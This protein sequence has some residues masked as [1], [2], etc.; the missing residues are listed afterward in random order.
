M[1]TGLETAVVLLSLVSLPFTLPIP[2]SSVEGDQSSSPVPPDTGHVYLQPD[3]F[4]L[5]E[6]FVDI[7][8]RVGPSVVTI[9]SRRTYTALV[10]EFPSAPFDMWS[11]PWDRDWERMFP[12][13]REREFI[14]EGLGSGVIATP[15]GYIISNHHVVGEADD[16]EVI[17][18]SG[19]RYRA[20]LVGTD[21]R[22]DI[23]VI[24]IDAEHPLPC[25]DFGTSSDLRVG[26]WV[27]AIGS[28][29]ALSQ[30]VT[31]GIVSFIGRSNVGLSDLENY[32]QTDAAIN[33][34]NSGG[35]LVNLHGELVGIN[36]AIASVTGGY[37]GVGFAIPVD[38]VLDVMNDLIDHGYV[39]RGWLGV[40]IQEVSPPLAR[41]F[42]V[43][44]EVVGGVL[45][46]DVVEGSPAE[47][48]GLRRGDIVLELN[49]VHTTDVADFRSD[50]A[51][52]GPGSGVRLGIMR[53]GRALEVDVVLG[54]RPGDKAFGPREEDRP[55]DEA[56]WRIRTLEERRARELG[57]PDLSGVEVLEVDP[58]GASGR[59]G[60]RAGD[61]IVEAGRQPVETVE[62]LRQ[63]LADSGE[64]AL[65]LVWRNGGTVYLVLRAE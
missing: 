1:S 35:A 63:R 48:A 19:E 28:P 14:Q 17:L 24:H 38:I 18:N 7:A 12:A 41:Q 62:D 59:A 53:D 26:E 20:D 32:I 30:T 46:S 43:P 37:Q 16:L 54:Q 11:N 29:F 31:Q 44:Q 34:G 55:I 21:P 47:D 56:G 36:T 39:L 5:S 64:E 50:I 45:I 25:V 10:P 52:A 3:A 22:T 33:P 13:P 51:S 4:Q 2:G 40:G 61:V 27:L 15:D 60:L 8:G 9:T 23:A 42:D 65:L 6:L 49:G 57:E 58:S